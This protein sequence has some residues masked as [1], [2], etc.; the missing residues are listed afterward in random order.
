MGCLILDVMMV[1]RSWKSEEVMAKVMVADAEQSLFS[2]TES[3]H[4]P[5]THEKF[6]ATLA[7]RIKLSTL[8]INCRI[9]Q[10]GHKI[11]PQ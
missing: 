6:T 10:Q 9:L 7:T 8:S 1:L 4:L 11:P 3:D 5:S 2:P